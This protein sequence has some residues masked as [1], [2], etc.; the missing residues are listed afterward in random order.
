MLCTVA[1]VKGWEVEKTWSYDDRDGDDE[2]SETWGAVKR[3]EENWKTFIKA[4]HAPAKK[5]RNKRQ[6]LLDESENEGDA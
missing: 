1:E 5:R 4:G 6:L 3:L 2:D